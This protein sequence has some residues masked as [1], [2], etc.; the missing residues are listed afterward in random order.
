MYT[1]GLIERRGKNIYEGIDLLAHIIATTAA[2][3]DPDLVVDKVSEGIGAPDDDVAL[4]LVDIEAAK[5][6]FNIEVPPNRPRY[7]GSDGA[8]AA[9]STGAVSTRTSPPRSFSR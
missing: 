8:C 4:L 1:D 6:Q 3:I 2:P 9:G 7:P 5:A